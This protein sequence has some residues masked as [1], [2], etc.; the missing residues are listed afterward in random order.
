[1]PT[2][3]FF[4]DSINSRIFKTKNNK[5]AKNRNPIQLP[6]NSALF[7][8]D[9][10]ILWPLRNWILH[11]FPSLF[12]VCFPSVCNLCPTI[13]EE[14]DECVCPAQGSLF[15]QEPVRCHQTPH[16]GLQQTSRENQVQTCVLL[17]TDLSSQGISLYV[18]LFHVEDL[19][20]LLRLL[21]SLYLSEKNLKCSQFNCPYAHKPA[22]LLM[23]LIATLFILG[24]IEIE[25]YFK[26][27]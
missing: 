25:L 22:A 20:Y 3:F 2:C 27:R 17:V 13:L 12:Y 7:F 16:E 23:L 15:A 19:F 10:L 21:F 8:S 4:P 14:E 1:M 18:T 26:G 11:V 6:L 9:G 5:Q 24:I